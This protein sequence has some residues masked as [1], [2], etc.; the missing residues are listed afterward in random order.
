[1]PLRD[2]RY[3]LEA[4]LDSVTPRTKIVYICHPNN[5]TGTMNTRDEL[6]DWFDLVPDTC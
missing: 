3:D 5:P 6:D 1:M 2:G 4:M